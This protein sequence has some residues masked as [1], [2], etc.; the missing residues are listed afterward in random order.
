VITP[1]K[2]KALITIAQA[3]DALSIPADDTTNDSAIGQLIAQIS[4]AIEHYCDRVFAVQTYRDQITYPC[5]SYGEP[6]RIRQFPI[7]TDDSGEAL[8]TLKVDGN[9][10][11]PSTYDLDID[12]GRVYFITNGWAGARAVVDYTAG[13]DPIPPDVQAAATT[14]LFGGWMSRGRDPSVKSEAIFDV[15][16]VVYQDTPTGAGE[17]GPPEQVCGLLTPYRMMFA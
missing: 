17:A 3:K 10:V 1:A 14:W 8:L 12:F 9:V 2:S 5:L 11:D 4:A 13:F 16:T 15:M 6:L 7:R